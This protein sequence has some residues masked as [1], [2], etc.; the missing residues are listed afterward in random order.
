MPKQRSLLLISYGYP[1]IGGAASERSLMLS[2]YLSELGWKI[3]VYCAAADAPHLFTDERAVEL[4]P[5]AVSVERM[6]LPR[7]YQAIWSTRILRAGANFALLTL[8]PTHFWSSACLQRIRQEQHE[9]PDVI[10][11]TSPPHSVHTIGAGLKQD[12][13]TPWVMD[14][15]DTWIENNTAR[16]YTP[17]HQ[18]VSNWHYRRA[19]LTASKIVANTPEMAQLIAS[20]FPQRSADVV[21]IRNGYD[22]RLFQWASPKRPSDSTEHTRVILY[23][24]GTYEGWVT[25]V[26]EQLSRALRSRQANDGRPIQ[27]Y[28]IGDLVT[29]EPE[30]PVGPFGLGHQSIMDVPD[31][32][33]G[34]DALLLCMLPQEAGSSRVLLKAYGYARA[35]KP[36]LYLGPRNATYDYLVQRA[37]VHQFELSEIE[38]AAQWLLSHHFKS[39]PPEPPAQDVIQDSFYAR[40]KRL[41]EILENE[42]LENSG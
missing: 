30:N 2:R 33:L 42:I 21:T 23:S 5:P 8:D 34:A 24:G 35:G 19:I 9:R 20:K 32:L 1:P 29:T 14:L 25:G 13:G 6:A 18:Y 41:S 26:L 36:I 40:A 31:Y 28:A 4:I 17:I 22:E 3:Y 15:R 10:L 7:W 38:L 12:W 11:T 39:M 16:W 37:S 27:L